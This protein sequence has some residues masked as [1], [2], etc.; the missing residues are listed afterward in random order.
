M[1]IEVLATPEDVA[2]RAADVIAREARAAVRARGR[3]L[4]ATSGGATP[5]AML[6][7]LA[8]EDLPWDVVH[9]FQVDERVTPADDAHRNLRQ[10][11]E[12]LLDHVAI[13]PGN[14]HA[15]PVED[16]DLPVAAR[17]YAAELQAMAGNPPVLD[18]V[19]LGLGSDGH[20]ASLIDGD[21]ALEVSDAAT[22]L[23]GPYNGFRRMTLTLPVLAAA[24]RIVWGV[25]GEEKREALARLVAG[26]REIPAGRVPAQRA[27]V[28]ADAGAAAGL[29]RSQ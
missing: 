19:H 20:T 10:L 23:T 28:L 16:A 5:R 29:P 18:L 21:A 2:R 17:R 11:R 1:K 4:V 14:L 26:D 9:W 6:A 24:G 22:A 8:G 12:A 27:H 3:F 13:P 7:L 25:T 15:M